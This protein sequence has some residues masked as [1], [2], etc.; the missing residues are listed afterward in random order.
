MSEPFIGQITMFG[1]NFAPRGWALCDGQLLTISTHSILFSILGTTYGGDGRTTFGL[2]DMRGRVPMHFGTGT[3]LTTRNI[4]Q[5][6]GS[7]THP[8]IPAEMPAHSHSFN[9]PCSDEDG[10]QTSPSNNFPARTSNAYF[11]EDDALMGAGTTGSSG[12]GQAHNNMP[13]FSCVAFI[14]AL[15]GRLPTRN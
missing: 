8:L 13:P 10:E 11:D 9:V 4:G 2:P 5:K 3:G 12:S 14:I 1:G 7:E 6:G 15:R